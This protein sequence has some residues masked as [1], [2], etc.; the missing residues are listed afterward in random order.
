[1]CVVLTFHARLRQTKTTDWPAL[2]LPRRFLRLSSRVLF[3]LLPASVNEKR[4]D[5]LRDGREIDSRR[6]RCVIA[7]L[8]KSGRN[9]ETWTTADRFASYIAKLFHEIFQRTRA[10]LWRGII[11]V[12]FHAPFQS[13]NSD[14]RLHST[15]L[16]ST[17]LRVLSNK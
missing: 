17:H 9:V 12:S 11:R 6:K 14:D 10:R 15:F 16:R 13:G 3:L 5:R 4:L 8:P 7:R 1:V 2:A